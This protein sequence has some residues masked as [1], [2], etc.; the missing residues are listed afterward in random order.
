MKVLRETVHCRSSSSIHT[1]CNQPLV[2]GL[3]VHY[4]PAR[5]IAN[6][7]LLGGKAD[8]RSKVVQ[9]ILRALKSGYW[10]LNDPVGH[11]APR[12]VYIYRPMSFRDEIDTRHTTPMHNGDGNRARQPPTDRPGEHC[13]IQ[14]APAGIQNA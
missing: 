11:V 7:S 4:T 12:A 2:G 5:Q 13:S 6:V 10:V 8:S 3:S 1:D 14:I 9:A